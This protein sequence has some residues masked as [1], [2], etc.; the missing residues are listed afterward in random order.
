MIA[1]LS[2]P[3]AAQT[4]GELPQTPIAAAA[5][6]LQ[7]TL[8]LKDSRILVEDETTA[9]F[10]GTNGSVKRMNECRFEYSVPNRAKGFFDLSKLSGDYRWRRERNVISL[11]V[12]GE[13]RENAHCHDKGY[14]TYCWPYFEVGAVGQEQFD[15]IV[16][17]MRFLQTASCPPQ[18]KPF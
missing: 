13:G 16:R 4:P 2:A 5:V 6:I 14:G 15:R 18:K 17:A 11:T 8:L 1:V 7:I 10:L 12:A 3:V 9:R